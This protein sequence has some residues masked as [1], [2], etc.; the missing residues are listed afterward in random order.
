MSWAISHWATLT[1]ERV[2]L[3]KPGRCTEK[4][5]FRIHQKKIDQRL[6]LDDSAL[7]NLIEE[8]RNSDKPVGTS[9]T[10]LIVGGADKL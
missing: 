4:E 6:V 10:F 5:K 2:N 9:L 1:S 3:K 7:E 8:Y